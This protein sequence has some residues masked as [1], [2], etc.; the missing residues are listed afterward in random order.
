MNRLEEIVRM[1]RTI[2][3]N[4]EK[5]I[6]RVIWIDWKGERDKQIEREWFKK[7]RIEREREFGIKRLY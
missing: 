2:Y 4:T 6:V 1:I 5:E 7:I 3:D